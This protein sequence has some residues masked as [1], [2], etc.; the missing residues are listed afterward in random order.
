MNWKTPSNCWTWEDLVWNRVLPKMFIS[1][2]QNII[3]AKSEISLRENINWIMYFSFFH[4]NKH[5]RPNSSLYTAQY[6][7]VDFYLYDLLYMYC[8]SITLWTLAPVRDMNP[9]PLPLSAVCCANPTSA[10]NGQSREI[11]KYTVIGQFLH[12]PAETCYH[13]YFH[14]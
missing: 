10:L 1:F 6:I 5:F 7:P 4:E 8:I 3:L 12:T 9:R 13:L 14:I 2:S 11:V